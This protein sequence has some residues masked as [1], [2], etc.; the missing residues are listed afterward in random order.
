MADDVA[1]SGDPFEGLLGDFD[2]DLAARGKPVMGRDA[3][4]VPED[5]GGW[6]T[7][8]RAQYVREK[9]GIDPNLPLSEF[10]AQALKNFG[11]QA[12]PGLAPGIDAFHAFQEGRPWAGAGN[13]ALAAAE[14]ASVP[15]MGFGRAAMRAA[16]PPRTAAKYA[17]S[18]PNAEVSAGGPMDAPMRAYRGSESNKQHFR[19]GVRVFASDDP[20]I[21]ATYASGGKAPNIMPLDIQFK[22]PITY[23]LNSPTP[24]DRIRPPPGHGPDMMGLLGLPS[25]TD[26]LARFARARGHDGV[27]FKNV[28]D[29]VSGGGS[30][31][32]VFVAL[33]KGTVKSPLTGATI[34]GAGAAA[35]GGAVVSQ[36]RTVQEA[37]Q[38]PSGSVFV[39]P[40]GRMKVR[41]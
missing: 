39:T 13:T 26:E 6:D 3:G 16:L 34:Y 28:R 31:S 40:D 41:P 36:P 9:F 12:T 37:E 10:A 11:I 8:R 1:Q 33:G 27:I 21:A 35:A 14:V 29:A 2:A 22:N 20:E 25:S 7:A 5:F 19:Q 23:S 15:F 30:P 18:P 4:P 24:Y 32:T 38:L 17:P